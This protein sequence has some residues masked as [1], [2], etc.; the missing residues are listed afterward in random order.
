[1]EYWSMDRI[2]RENQEKGRFF[3]SPGAMRFFR[4]RVHYHVYQGPGGIYFVTSE[5]GPHAPRLF[6][7]RRFWPDTAKIDTWPDNNEFQVY[8]S[9]N[10]AHKA[11][12]RAARGN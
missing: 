8:R 1:M 2:I 4:S 10:G 5:Q 3:F 7:V 11:A 9:R 6:T 12:M